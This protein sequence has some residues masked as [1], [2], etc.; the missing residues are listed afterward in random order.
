VIDLRPHVP[1]GSGVFWNQTC[2]EPTPLVDA[3]LDQVPSIGPVRAFVGMTLNKRL[4]TE[5][6]ADLEVVS[7]GG[8]G[9]LRRLS[10]AGRLTV[11]P[12]SY[13]ELPE[14]FARRELPVDVAL[15]QVS[16]P[17]A[18]G[19]CS[20]GLGVD[21]I[22]DAVPHA[23]VLIAEI[24]EQMPATVGSAKLHVDS[25]A[26]VVRTDRPL[27]QLPEPP[28]GEVERRIAA[29]VA[30]L[31][32]DGDTLQMGVGTLPAAIL[33]ALAGHQDLGLHTGLIS[34]SALR[35]YQDG[36]LTGARKE[37]DRGVL[38]TGAAFG[39]PALYDAVGSLPIE[40]RPASYTHAP[41]T[42][43]Q[44]HRLVAI[45]SAIQ[46]DLSGNAGAERIGGCWVGAVGGQVD[47]SRAAAHTGARSIIALRAAV[48]GRST[49]VPALE[50]GAPT[51]VADD[52]DAVVTEYGVARIRGRTP[53]QRA[54]DLIAIAAPDHREH[55]ASVST[56]Q[57]KGLTP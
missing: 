27:V 16:P 11:V 13:S 29:H 39:S 43:A 48:N 38:V 21:Y 51:T 57:Q 14:L 40:F 9:E 31:V 8:L 46:I 22:A 26:A 33:D 12:C 50:Q 37:I 30:G 7:Y 24:N 52:I 2:A 55:L 6:P 19:W 44:L 23:R 56:D 41:A 1:A 42:L 17:D 18:D 10:R 3:L 28:V 47:F 49:I 53:E 5:P 4:T 34:D 15:L 54:A 25:F 45:N 32:D 20:L 36:V 35:L